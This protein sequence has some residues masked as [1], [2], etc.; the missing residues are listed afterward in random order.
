MT[1]G[2]YTKAEKDAWVGKLQEFVQGG[3]NLVL[4]DGALRALAD[5]T[6]IPNRAIAQQTVYVGQSTFSDGDNATLEHP[7]AAGVQQPGARFNGGMR[8]QTYESTPLGFAIQNSRSGGDE[9]HA[10]QYDVRK[11]AFEAAGGTVAATSADSGTRDAGPVYDRVTVGEI[12]LGQGRIRIAGALLP[13][14]S[15]AYDH[16]LGIEP[17]AL[18]YTGY[19]IARNLLDW[20]RPRT[21]TSPPPPPPPADPSPPPPPADT[22]PGGTPPADASTPPAGTDTGSDSGGAAGDA[23]RPSSI[24]IAGGRIAISRAGTG[25]VKV[26]CS[27]APCEG[28]LM[29]KVA[30]RTVGMGSFDLAKGRSAKVAFKLNRRGRALLRSSRSLKVLLIAVTDGRTIGSRAVRLTRR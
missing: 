1:T 12:P 18:T 15:Q 5:L 2:A 25:R 7:L 17:Y 28:R 3:G 20:S 26:T 19:A 9:A 24:T 21:D 29:V 8:R 4:T 22:P 23:A 6:D 10:V 30:G 13:Q 14:P 27:Q 11:S 16:P